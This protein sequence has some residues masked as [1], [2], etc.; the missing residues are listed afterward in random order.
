M[1][2]TG[3]E[4][5]EQDA[6][7]KLAAWADDRGDELA[8]I[9]RMLEVIV[10][11]RSDMSPAQSAVVGEMNTALGDL[12]AGDAG[13]PSEM[14]TVEITLSK[15]TGDTH[16]TRSYSITLD[17]EGVRAACYGSEWTRGEGSEPWSNPEIVLAP[18]Q[19]MEGDLHSFAAEFEDAAFDRAFRL[20]VLRNDDPV[21]G[22]PQDEIENLLEEAIPESESGN[23]SDS[24][25]QVGFTSDRGAA[26]IAFA[27]TFSKLGVPEPE[28]LA[29]ILDRRFEKRA[30]KY[31]QAAWSAV[32]VLNPLLAARPKW[33]AIYRKLELKERAQSPEHG[34]Q[35]EAR[36]ISGCIRELQA[37]NDS[38]MLQSGDDSGLKT[39]WDE[40][41]V[42]QQHE[43]SISWPVYEETIRALIAAR[44]EKLSIT[45]LTALW[46]RS[47][48]GGDWSID[49]DDGSAPVPSADD[50]VQHL[51]TELLSRANDFTNQRIQAY[52]DR[53]WTG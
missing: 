28:T 53:Y 3:Q 34:K 2:D 38:A 11:K 37:M 44:V 8:T 16:G 35:V 33:A 41:C 50:V 46:L 23:N 47:E 30:R 10:E 5:D 27:E 4:F 12:I 6:Q 22:P 42:Q 39:V 32:T 17:D 18:G 29:A 15:G 19:R 21:E 9:R 49:N 40:I 36:A 48:Q 26:L 24:L 31:S 1:S 51:F 14:M 13:L 45:D 43:Q 20:K 52:L 7:R 25:E